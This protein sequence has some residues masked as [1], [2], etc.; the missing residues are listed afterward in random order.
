M[1]KFETIRL[2]TYRLIM[3]DKNADSR[4]ARRNM[5]KAYITF[6]SEMSNLTAK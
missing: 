4:T 5:L 1:G 6:A 3:E 2:E